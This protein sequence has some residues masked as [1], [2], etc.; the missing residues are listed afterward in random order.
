LMSPPK[1]PPARVTVAAWAYVLDP[2]TRTKARTECFSSFSM[3]CPF[4]RGLATGAEVH[5]IN[6]QDA[7]E[8]ASSGIFGL[9]EFV[10]VRKLRRTLPVELPKQLSWAGCAD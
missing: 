7:D 4:F 10:F 2:S 8:V 9:A 6:E 1:P 3:L 5:T